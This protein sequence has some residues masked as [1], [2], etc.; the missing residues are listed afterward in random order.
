VILC[1]KSRIAAGPTAGTDCDVHFQWL[2]FEPVSFVDLED[3][4]YVDMQKVQC[5][6]A[7]LFLECA[8]L[9]LLTYVWWTICVSQLALCC[10]PQ[11]LSVVSKDEKGRSEEGF[12]VT[13][14]CTVNHSSVDRTQFGVTC[15][16]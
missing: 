3:P 5:L 14:G 6:L 4:G 2:L 10:V 13:D 8:V 11:L 15:S 7:K 9:I 12:I 1:S 16:E